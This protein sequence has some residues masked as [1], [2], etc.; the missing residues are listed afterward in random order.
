MSAALNK[1]QE[2]SLGVLH[3]SRSLCTS[4]GI[5]KL[6]LADVT[7]IY[8]CPLIFQQYHTQ[9]THNIPLSQE[10]RVPAASSGKIWYT[11]N[12]DRAHIADTTH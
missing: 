11:I 8:L 1:A 7:D 3:L 4:L 5:L 6:F 2:A 12:W 10:I 9:W